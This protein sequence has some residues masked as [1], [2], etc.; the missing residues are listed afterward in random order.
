MPY[1]GKE[2]L[3]NKGPINEASVERMTRGK[4]TPILKDAKT[5]KTRKGKAKV[6]SKGTNLNAE[7]SLW[8]QL[9]DINSLFDGG[10]F[11][12]Q[13]DIVVEKEV[14]VAEEK[15]VAEEEEVAEN[16]KEKEEEDYVEE[17]VIALKSMGENIDNLEQTGVRPAEVAEV[18]NEEQCNSLAI[19]VYTG[20]LQVAFPT[21]EA[22]DDAGAEPRIEE[23]S[24]DCPKPKE[25][26]RKGTAPRIKNKRKR[27]RKGG[28]RNIMKSHR[29]LRMTELVYFKL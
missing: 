29:R 12:D 10:I 6:D 3:E 27:R 11:A 24:E 23:Q 19:V 26:K 16:E 8:R 20:L 5:S 4:D 9:K 14:A 28:E 7:T 18:T 25:K 1:V 13:E 2:I 22:A 17:I 15:V 21:Q